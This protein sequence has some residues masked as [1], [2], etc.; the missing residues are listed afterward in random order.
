M[1]R[2]FE[3]LVDCDCTIESFLKGKGYSSRICNLLKK[4]LGLVMV[5]DKPVFV[6]A[7]VKKGDTLKVI[8]KENP[9]KID[10]FAYELDIVY[11]DEDIAVINKM[12]DIAV[13]ST[14]AHYGKS[15]MNALAYRWGNFVY[16][17][18][19]R[20]DKGTSGLMIVAKN[21][22]AHSILSNQ[23]ASD[24]Y[25][26]N[27][28]VQR[29]YIALVHNFDSELASSGKV[30]ADIGVPNGNS[31]VRGVVESGGKYA[32]TTY[33]VIQS[34]SDFSIVRL[35]LATG[36]TH[37]IRV[38]MAHIGHPLLGDDL[39]GGSKELIARPAL[40]SA[41]LTFTHPITKKFIELSSNIPEDM[42]SI[43]DKY[44]KY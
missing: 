4:E 29:E 40:H 34:F 30:I 33:E 44:S 15:L 6:V 41:K 38:H 32:E 28:Q 22:L 20:L 16:H 25:S 19:N 26:Y 8:L 27:K 42:Q 31:L 23:I 35:I 10:T 5:N 3:Y 13:I 36:R 39:Y 17:P 24:K 21:S 18:V 43:V 7:Q 11:E 12:A 14:N 37:Q 9:S 1:E 2:I